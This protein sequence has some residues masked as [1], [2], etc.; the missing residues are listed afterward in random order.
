MVSRDIHHT[1]NLAN[2]VGRPFGVK[3]RYA[4]DS[5]KRVF[6]WR[7]YRNG[8]FIGQTSVQTEVINRMEKYTTNGAKK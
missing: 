6:A 5:V 1:T 2:E 7:F 8:T 4:Y 3:C